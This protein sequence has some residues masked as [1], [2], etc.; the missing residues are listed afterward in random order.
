MSDV[1]EVTSET[2]LKHMIEQARI[3]KTSVIIRDAIE[4]RA[5]KKCCSK[6]VKII[7]GELFPRNKIPEFLSRK[8]PKDNT[9]EIRMNKGEKY[10]LNMNNSISCSKLVI[11]TAYA[12]PDISKFL[13]QNMPSLSHV[14]IEGPCH[15]HIENCMHLHMAT[16]NTRLSRMY[17]MD[18]I[19]L[20]TVDFRGW[21][22]V[23]SNKNA[24]ISIKFLEALP[25]YKTNV[26]SVYPRNI[27]PGTCL[28]YDRLM[29]DLPSADLSSFEI[30]SE[31]KLIISCSRSLI[32]PKIYNAK[33]I[34]LRTNM[35]VSPEISY[36]N[37]DS[38]Y[39]CDN[40]TIQIFDLSPTY[41][42]IFA[43]FN[44]FCNADCIH[45]IDRLLDI[46]GEITLKHLKNSIVITKHEF[47]EAFGD[48]IPMMNTKSA[49]K[50]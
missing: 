26:L 33:Q 45:V 21:W 9:I 4:P 32:L 28:D 31:V 25:I 2:K 30:N 40:I 29:I 7:L 50:V 49:A 1:F 10:M 34:E 12:E 27:L 14:Y 5:I 23:I 41:G 11:S 19:F 44:L 15:I 37:F 17:F 43:W 24:D 3:N 13:I 20:Q 22:E 48:I 46:A 42:N 6:F 18:E 36:M 16:S 47:H 39:K 38:I 8:F 35:S